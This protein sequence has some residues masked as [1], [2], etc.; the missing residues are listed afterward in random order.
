MAIAAASFSRKEDVS[1]SR[2]E[3]IGV[4]AMSSEAA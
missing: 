4:F 2:K 1:F 3:D